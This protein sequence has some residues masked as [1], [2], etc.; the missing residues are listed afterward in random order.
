MS[1]FLLIGLLCF[2]ASYGHKGEVDSPG[3][4]Y[5]VPVVLLLDL[6]SGN[7][8]QEHKTLRQVQCDY[9]KEVFAIKE[10]QCLAPPKRTYASVYQKTH[11]D[12]L[13][14]FYQLKCDG[15]EKHLFVTISLLI[16]ILCMIWTLNH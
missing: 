6:K 14:E 7:N 9:I 15:R 3:T 8:K 16:T 4:I 2:M 11:E 13:W 1:L 10:N 5:G 12:E